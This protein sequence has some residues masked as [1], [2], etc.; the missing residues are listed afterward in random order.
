[1]G[2][3]DRGGKINVLTFEIFRMLKDLFSTKGKEI[4]SSCSLSSITPP[5]L[6]SK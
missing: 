2:W 4:I 3:K 1:M 6:V 5:L